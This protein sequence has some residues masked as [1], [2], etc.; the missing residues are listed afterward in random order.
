MRD[1]CELKIIQE[2]RFACVKSLHS[3]LTLCNPMDQSPLGFSVHGILQARTLE[4]VASALS[5]GSSG[6][7]DGTWTSCIAGRFFTI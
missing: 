7:W 2:N 4:W 5:R 3:H 6:P 1:P